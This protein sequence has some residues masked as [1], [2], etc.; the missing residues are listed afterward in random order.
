MR[1]AI[2]ITTRDTIVEPDQGKHVLG[3]ADATSREFSLV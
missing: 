3:S 1:T 2:N